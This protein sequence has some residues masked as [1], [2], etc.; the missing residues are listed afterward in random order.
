MD[1][2]LVVQIN[3]TKGREPISN[4]LLG[5][6]VNQLHHASRH[7]KKSCQPCKK[8]TT[9]NMSPSTSR[10][11]LE[12]AKYRCHVVEVALF[13]GAAVCGGYSSFR[14]I[15]VVRVVAHLSR[16]AKS[17]LMAWDESDS[18]A[19]NEVRVSPS[20]EGGKSKYRRVDHLSV[21]TVRPKQLV[22]CGCHRQA[23]NLLTWP[24]LAGPAHFQRAHRSISQLSQ[25]PSGHQKMTP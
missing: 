5:V 9:Q 22:V 23:R 14:R 21:D 20:S 19:S 10:S 15:R 2:T 16:H 25:C 3:L 11:L 1:A 4:N 13:H 18:T 8:T 7:A 6:A 17:S 24:L 12:R